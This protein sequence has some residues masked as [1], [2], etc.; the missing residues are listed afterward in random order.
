MV[1]LAVAVGLVACGADQESEGEGSEGALKSARLPVDDE[2]SLPASATD[3]V[4]TFYDANGEGSCSFDATPDDLDVVALAHPEYNGSKACGACL[5][6]K[7]P[8]GI[9]TVRVTDRCPGCESKGVTLDLGAKAFAKIAEPKQGRVDVSYAEVPCSVTGNVAYRFKDGSSKWWTAIQ[10]R[11]HKHPIAK[12]EYEKDG[13]W[14]AIP[15]LDYNYFVV[16]K[17]V[18]DQ[19]NGLKLRVTSDDGQTLVDT[20]PGEIEA[21]KTITGDAQFR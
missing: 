14:V 5:R 20:L 16:Q 10:V 19:P 7:G 13:A 11:N 21:D 8:K 12:L 1:V 15:R 2:R 18:G 3:G 9:V 17:G 6:V 4:A